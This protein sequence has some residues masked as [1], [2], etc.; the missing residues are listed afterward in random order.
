VGKAYSGHED[1]FGNGG[2][3]SGDEEPELTMIQAVLGGAKGCTKPR[4]LIGVSSHKPMQQA[5]V[6]SS[7]CVN[8]FHLILEKSC[9]ACFSEAQQHSPTLQQRPASAGGLSTLKH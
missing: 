2:G 7:S 5:A 3:G 8:L 4:L 9:G 6:S 1:E